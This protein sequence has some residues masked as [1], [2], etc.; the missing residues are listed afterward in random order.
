MKRKATEKKTEQQHRFCLFPLQNKKTW[1]FYKN[2][3]ASFWTAEEI[4]LSHDKPH[5]ERS[6][7]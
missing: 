6:Y 2:H 1:S 4:D 3:E 5:L 7:G